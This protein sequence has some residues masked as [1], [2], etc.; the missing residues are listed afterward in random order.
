MLEAIPEED[1][2]ADVNNSATTFEIQVNTELNVIRNYLRVT[3]V[4]KRKDDDS[5]STLTCRKN[6]VKLPKIFIMKFSGNP[7]E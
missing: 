1:I 3:D 5:V 6:T 2:E 7:I 4:E